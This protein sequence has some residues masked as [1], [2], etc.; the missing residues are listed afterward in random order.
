[1]PEQCK[2]KGCER[3]PEEGFEECILHCE[4][5]TDIDSMDDHLYQRFYAEFLDYVVSRVRSSRALIHQAQRQELFLNFFSADDDVSEKAKRAMGDLS[6]EVNGIEFPAAR[7]LNFDLSSESHPPRIRKSSHRTIL[8]RMK[9]IRFVKCGFR[10]SEIPIPGA[11]VNFVGCKFFKHVELDEF[12]MLEN[13]NDVLFDFCQFYDGFSAYRKDKD[14]VRYDCQLFNE[15]TFNGI[16]MFNNIEFEEPILL[17]IHRNENKESH[18]QI[19]D[20]EFESSFS[21]D[22]SQSNSF[23]VGHCVFASKFDI[24]ELETDDFN[25]DSSEFRGFANCIE[26]EC[27]SFWISNCKFQNVLAC[28]SSSFGVAEES[29]HARMDYTTFNDLLNLRN[30]KFKKGLDIET[31]NLKSPPNFLNTDINSKGSNRETFRI[32]KDS[33]DKVGNHTEANRFFAEEMRKLME[34]V[35]FQKNPF[36]KSLL[37]I[38][39]GVSNFGQNYVLPIVWF[40]VTLIAFTQI[41][42]SQT[43]SILDFPDEE[44]ARIAGF[45]KSFS[46]YLNE[47][48]SNIKPFQRFLV[49]GMEFVSLIFYIIFIALIYQTVVALKRHVR[50]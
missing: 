24:R 2:R 13:Q 1:M 15:C 34:E 31:I 29:T 11:N 17:S 42:R 33:F 4:K 28:G 41:R 47:M 12:S 3:P 27:G 30:T 48:A 38:N 23:L 18:L 22:H 43:R 36:K 26:M 9:D 37:W 40:V 35:S 50:R 10:D 39:F 6:C 20:C 7:E 49:E 5:P 8:Q 19:I 45:A 44:E 14:R 21:L 46:G 25:I 32:I 16:I